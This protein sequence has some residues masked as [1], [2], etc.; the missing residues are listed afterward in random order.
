LLASRGPEQLG[1]HGFQVSPSS[2]V[3]VAVEMEVPGAKVTGWEPQ[4]G[5]MPAQQS[6][7]MAP[8]EAVPKMQMDKDA[9][10]RGAGQADGQKPQ[11]SVEP[12]PAK[13]PGAQAARGS[14]AEGP[15]KGDQGARQ[16]RS[17]GAE[18]E[19]KENSSK[20]QDVKDQEGK[21]RRDPREHGA[22][23]PKEPRQQGVSQNPVTRP[24][25]N[26]TNV[27]NIST[28]GAKENKTEGAKV[29]TGRKEDIRTP[30][31][32]PVS[33]GSCSA[34]GSHDPP[35]EKT[36]DLYDSKYDTGF[37]PDQELQA[38]S[39]HG[40]NYAEPPVPRPLRQCNWTKG[41]V[42]QLE[43]TWAVQADSMGWAFQGPLSE[44][45]KRLPE[46]GVWVCI[47]P[48][49]IV[50]QPCSRL[51]H[52][53]GEPELACLKYHETDKEFHFW[54]W[55]HDP[56]MRGWIVR[57]ENILQLRP[58]R[59][60]YIEGDFVNVTWEHINYLRTTARGFNGTLSREL[61][62]KGQR[63]WACLA[64]QMVSVL[65]NRIMPKNGV[66][67]PLP[68]H[69]KMRPCVHWAPEWTVEYFAHDLVCMKF[70]EEERVFRFWW[71]ISC[72]P[73]R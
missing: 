34:I 71:D 36:L 41:D 44:S 68:V 67:R 60:P 19:G 50:R 49:A 12:K 65:H 11:G 51:H 32:A 64:P 2:Q 38:M 7:P 63:K 57:R 4:A 53:D 24:G 35:K 42:V 18:L 39:P 20:S 3:E 55:N 22:S 25:T 31:A 47:Y 15:A 13:G 45:E 73:R 21:K 69:E 48:E 56:N 28:S 5:V 27:V 29:E 26:K 23:Q 37:C 14:V 30:K 33:R 46:Y 17:R 40:L 1:G 66:A 43:W 10:Y 61:A 62:P 8:S 58:I 9:V 6:N 72:S 54:R 16:E 70:H 52:M 59:C